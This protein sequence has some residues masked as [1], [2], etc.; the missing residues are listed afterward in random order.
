MNNLP[1]ELV[2]GISSFLDYDDLKH[3]L[4]VS[5]SF[6]YAAENWS[7]AFQTFNLTPE[8]AEKFITTYSGHRLQ[9]LKE[10]VFETS[11]P[12]LKWFK[13]MPYRE[14]GGGFEYEDTDNRYR[15]TKHDIDARD[16]DFTR[17]I[18]FL[19]S[20]LKALDEFG[21]GNVHL[22]I[23]TPTI[24][25]DM[26]EWGVQRAFVSWRVH[27][28]SPDDLPSVKSVQTLTIERPA[29]R[30]PGYYTITFL[31]KLDARVVLDIAKKLPNLGALWCMMGGDEWNSNY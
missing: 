16:K 12:E 31:R 10:V 18:N 21:T 5:R 4:L 20:T 13:N 25:F 24:T 2:D 30:Y 19:F 7:Q 14:V 15:E 17:Q 23:I 26:E 29:S 11:F 27:L 9:Y 1:Q 3:T 28:L 22:R 6:Q 8:N